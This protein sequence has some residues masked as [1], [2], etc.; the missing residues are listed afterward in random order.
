MKKVRWG[1][2]QGQGPIRATSLMNPEN[3]VDGESE[4]G[5]KSDVEGGDSG[6][7]RSSV[8]E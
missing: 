1:A 3:D 8:Q 2:K 5:I 4:N 6:E 7:I